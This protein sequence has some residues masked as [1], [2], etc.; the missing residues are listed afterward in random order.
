MARYSIFSRLLS[1]GNTD[2]ALVTLRSCLL[3]PLMALVVC[4]SVATPP[5]DMVP[6][7]E[8]IQPGLLVEDIPA[9]PEGIQR[10]QRSGQYAFLVQR[11]TPGIVSIRRHLGTRAVNQRNHAALQEQNFQ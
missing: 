2:L 4:R 6:S 8:V 5:G 10:T 9:I 7:P 1:V 3:K 11:L